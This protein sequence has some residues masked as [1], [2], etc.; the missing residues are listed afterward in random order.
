M[1]KA[2]HSILGIALLLAVCGGSW[3]QS[4]QPPPSEG[5]IGQP[6]QPQTEPSQQTPSTDQRG[7]EQL[8]LIVEIFKT[9][10]SEAEAA[11]EAKDREDRASLDWKTIVLNALLVLVAALQFGALIVQAYWLRRTVK[12]SEAAAIAATRSADAV[13]SQL[14]AYVVVSSAKIHN[15]GF[16]DPPKAQIVIKNSGQT[17]AFDAVSW[18]G[19]AI[20]E[21]PLNF[22]LESPGKDF[23]QSRST[24]GPGIESGHW[25]TAAR[26]LNQIEFEKINA[27]SAAIYVHGSIVYKDAFN[28]ERFTHFR[29]MYGGGAGA[30]PM[31]AMVFC[32]EG[33]DAN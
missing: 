28:I 27:G 20:G 19:V 22:K 2:H 26:A 12:V 25:I 11:Q 8:P 17:P 31:G 30:S 15:F 32:E 24:L 1:L 5:E 14:R 21:F 13:V 23:K 33:N 9:R 6:Q 10:K 7:T 18:A 16:V 4:Q 3:A 29:L